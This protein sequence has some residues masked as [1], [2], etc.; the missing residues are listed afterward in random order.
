MRVPMVAHTPTPHPPRADVSPA[1]RI[2]IVAVA[3]ASLAACSGAARPRARRLP[4]GSRLIQKK[5][6]QA[7]YASAGRIER[8]LHDADG[9]GVAEAI[10]FYR[11][12]G[13][14][15]RAEIDTD[16]DH[17]LDRW[18]TLRPDGSVAISAYARGGSGDPDAWAYADEDG[19]IYQTDFDDDGDGQVD[20]TD[21]AEE[22]TPAAS[23][24]SIRNP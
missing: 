8:L 22:M 10:V 16:G 12:D 14:P 19:F 24:Q 11:K 3:C 4:D 23:P 15:E 17:V 20:R 18:E 6:F 21:R 5:E 9:D 7:L 13:K 1:L 2:L